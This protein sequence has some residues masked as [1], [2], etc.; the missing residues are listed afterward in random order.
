[1]T[2]SGC[3]ENIHVPSKTTGLATKPTTKNEFACLWDIIRIR[4]Q[5]NADYSNIMDFNNMFA[6]MNT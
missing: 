5:K 6:Q 4:K 1:M 3:T 2:K